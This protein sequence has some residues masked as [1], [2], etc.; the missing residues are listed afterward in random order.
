MNFVCKRYSYN[1]FDG[2][3]I[4]L[5]DIDYPTENT[6][7]AYKYLYAYVNNCF[8][9]VNGRF[10]EAVKNKYI[11]V[12]NDRSN[13]CLYHYRLNVI[14]TY[15]DQELSSYLISILLKYGSTPVFLN[16][17]ALV[18][19]NDM[20]IPPRIIHKR[21]SKKVLLNEEGI[22]S[23]IKHEGDQTQ[24]QRIGNKKFVL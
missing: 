16:D 21:K 8:A 24:I 2:K 17:D 7:F 14:E 6:G 22:P 19:L 9:F 23:I 11:S 15:A 5:A 12:Y 13:F 20:L 1:G 3:R 10:N 18:F 4:L